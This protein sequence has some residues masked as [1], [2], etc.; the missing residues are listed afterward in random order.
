VVV[1]A[2]G[3]LVVVHRKEILV[4]PVVETVVEE[5]QLEVQMQEHL[6]KEILVGLVLQEEILV[7]PVVEVVEQIHLLH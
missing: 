7:D 1:V 2:D 4:D 5:Q 6:V 3:M